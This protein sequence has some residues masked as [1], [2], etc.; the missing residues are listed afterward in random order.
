MKLFQMKTQLNLNLTRALLLDLTVSYV[1]GQKF[2]REPN[3]K[4]LLGSKYP[5]F[6]AF[7]QKGVQGVFGS[8]VNHEYGL[9]GMRQTFKIGT[10]GTSNITSNWVSSCPPNDFTTPISNTT[11]EAILFGSQIHC[12]LFKTLK[13]PCLQKKYSTKD[14]L[15]TTETERF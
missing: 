8:D 6:Y 10:L 3:R 4:V 11:D 5:T 7:Y 12:I 13:K 9:L 15:C 14:I 1:P 2:M